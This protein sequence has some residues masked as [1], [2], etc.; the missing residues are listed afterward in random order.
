LLYELIHGYA[1]FRAIKDTE[2]RQQII[3]NDIEF[4][5]GTSTLAKDLIVKLVQNN[6]KQRINIDKILAHP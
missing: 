6:P 1:P 5:A 3:A 4:G 2:K